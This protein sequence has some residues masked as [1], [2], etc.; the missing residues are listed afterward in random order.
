MNHYK[1]S[2]MYKEQVPKRAITLEI[3]DVERKQAM[4]AIVYCHDFAVVKGKYLP[5]PSN[6]FDHVSLSLGFTDTRALGKG[7]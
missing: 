5:K 7:N 6:I 3:C 1:I 4:C 2:D